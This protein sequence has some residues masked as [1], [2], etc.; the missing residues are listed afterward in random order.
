MDCE[1]L[2]QVRLDRIDLLDHRYRIS[3]VVDGA[4]LARSIA[5]AGLISP[6]VLCHHGEEGRYC[7]VSGFRRLAAMSCLG[8]EAVA[9]RVLPQE[10]P[11]LPCARIA[12]ADNAL[13]RC[14]NPMETA[15]ALAL[16]RSVTE[17]DSLFAEQVEALGLD[18][19]PSRA[20]KYIELVRLPEPIQQAVETGAIPMDI[21]I[22]LSRLE[23]AEAGALADLFARLRP[24]LGKQREILVLCREIVLREGSSILRLL[25]E[26]GIRNVFN[27]PSPDGNV[28]TASLRKILKRRR[29]P[30]LSKAEEA[31]EAARKSLKLP[32]DAQL[33]PPAS[34]EGR[35]YRLGLAFQSLEDLKRH[36][37]TLDRLLD[38]PALKKILD[39]SS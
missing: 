21:A 22:E 16:L 31:F 23:P 9:C 24:S 5:A 15:R 8:H 20:A 37:N 39:R 7:V 6:P 28:K 32:T 36:R 26:E 1:D 4:A 18:V 14:L 10:T 27:D 17:G 12:V 19:H 34:F 3:T 38:D 35:I 25:G 13:Q 29:F 30:A 2:F 11:P 33:S